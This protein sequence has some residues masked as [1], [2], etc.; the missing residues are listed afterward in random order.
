MIN[1]IPL[2]LLMHFTLVLNCVSII[3]EN[4]S[5]VDCVSDLCFNKYTQVHQ[6][7]SS[8]MVKK[9]LKPLTVETEKGPHISQWIKSKHAFNTWELEGKCSFFCL[10][11]GQISQ[12]NCLLELKRGILFSYIKANLVFYR[13]PKREC[14]TCGCT[15]WTE[16]TAKKEIEADLLSSSR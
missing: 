15:L 13:C 6:E 12:W 2:S 3:V 7:Q 10:A 9:Y 11:K 5:K 8:T 16:N 1:S 4:Y 14:H